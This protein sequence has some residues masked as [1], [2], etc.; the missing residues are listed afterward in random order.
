MEEYLK[1]LDHNVY[2]E[3]WLRQFVGD[4]DMPAR[5][6]G[7]SRFYM[8]GYVASRK[9]LPSQQAESLLEHDFLTLLEY[10]PR[11][12]RFVAQPFTI[13]WNDKNGKRRKYTPDVIV[14]YSCLAQF[15]EPWLK[16]TI[17][18]VK[19]RNKLKED[20][21]E[22]R[23]KFRAAIG[24]A[25]EFGC[26]F[27]LVTEQEI[28]TPFLQNARHLLSYEHP[29]QFE[30]NEAL[31]LERLFLVQNAMAYLKQSTPGEL[32]RAITDNT[33]H[34]AE[35]IPYLWSCIKKGIIGANLELPLTMKSPIWWNRNDEN[36]Q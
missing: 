36:R 20:W 5:K 11:V 27:H 35:L 19:P 32:I 29:S 10:D 14:K 22:L 24:W 9:G 17:F 33:E 3:S 26:T 12:E 34:Q 25:K 4:A 18:E 6:I 15:H 2:D 31:W 13:E 30:S 23:P 16:T 7:V 1:Q 8:R 28:R 21:D